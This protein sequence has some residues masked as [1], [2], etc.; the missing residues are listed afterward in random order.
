MQTPQEASLLPL[1]EEDSLQCK[2]SPVL[3]SGAGRIRGIPQEHPGAGRAW[4]AQSLLQSGRAS[5]ARSCPASAAQS[6][7]Q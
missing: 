3:E 1:Q 4:Q 2:S 6:N 7:L 5:S